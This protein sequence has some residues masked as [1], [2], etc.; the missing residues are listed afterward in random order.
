MPMSTLAALNRGAGSTTLSQ[1]G[2]LEYMTS[3]LTQK[4]NKLLLSFNVFFCISLFLY[5]MIMLLFT[6]KRET[7][8]FDTFSSDDDEIIGLS[9]PHFIDSHKNE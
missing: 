2:A 9:V 8:F 4:C 6:L 3:S 5:F 7:S 1:R